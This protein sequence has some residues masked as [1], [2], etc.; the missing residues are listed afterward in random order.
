[1]KAKVSKHTMIR[2]ACKTAIA[3]RINENVNDELGIDESIK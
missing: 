3:L 1:M 2:A